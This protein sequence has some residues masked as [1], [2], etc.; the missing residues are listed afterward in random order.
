MKKWVF[1]LFLLSN[2]SVTMQAQETD[3]SKKDWSKNETTEFYEPTVKVVTPAATIGAPPSDA[4]VLF[5]GKN[6][7]AWQKRD[8]SPSHWLLNNGEMTINLEQKGELLTKESF[9]DCQLHVEFRLPE[10]AKKGGKNNA[11]NSGVFLQDRYEVQIF[12]SYQNEVPIYSNGQAGS[13]YKQTPPMVNV[14]AK[15]GTWESF[16]ILYTAPKF[17]QNGTVEKPAYIT[18]MQNGVFILNHFEIQ[19]PI[20]WIG[21]PQYKPHGKAPIHLQS[22]GSAV[23]FRN[24]WIR[25]L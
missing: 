14:C 2:V 17:R 23:S 13:I 9:G 4:K 7:N 1:I 5:D 10:D 12:D 18:V 21:I 22:H 11:G 8:G 19:G 24:I 15:P 6:M 3:W 25:E 20:E 16:D